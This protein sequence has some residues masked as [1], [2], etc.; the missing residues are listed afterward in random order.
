MYEHIRSF[1][2]HPSQMDYLYTNIANCTVLH[3]L[4]LYLHVGLYVILTSLG[5]C[6]SIQLESFLH[7]STNGFSLSWRRSRDTERS[8]SLMS[9]HILTILLDVYDF[10]PTIGNIDQSIPVNQFSDA[11]HKCVTCGD[12]FMISRLPGWT[13]VSKVGNLKI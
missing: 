3:P 4:N 8:V 7:H 10:F 12:R 5:G 13:R 1:W 6:H 11:L 9:R 2:N